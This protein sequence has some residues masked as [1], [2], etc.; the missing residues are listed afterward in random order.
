MTGINARRLH[1]KYDR[2]G[3]SIFNLETRKQKNES[4]K[5]ESSRQVASAR[6]EESPQ[7]SLDEIFCNRLPVLPVIIIERVR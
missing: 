7:K 2:A 5:Q 4:G 6:L 3:T 1:K